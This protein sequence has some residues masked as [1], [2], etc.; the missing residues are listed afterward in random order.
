[1]RQYRINYGQGQVSETYTSY[2]QVF[3][4]LRRQI[5]YSR[6][7]GQSAGGMF[8]QVYVLDYGWTHRG[9]RQEID[10]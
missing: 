8:I 5:D 10:S 1:M 3:E 4:A 2:K 7:I 6:R 9:V